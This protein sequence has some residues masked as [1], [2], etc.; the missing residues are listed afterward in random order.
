MRHRFMDRYGYP[1]WPVKF[2]VGATH[3]TPFG[4]DD[5]FRESD[6]PL[7]IHPATDRGTYL[8]D[9]E[10]RTLD[11]FAPFE[12]ARALLIDSPNT[13]F[14]TILRLFVAGADFELRIM[15]M[16]R[17]DIDQYVMALIKEKKRIPKSTFLGHAGNAGLSVGGSGHH[18]HLEIVSNESESPLLEK[19]VIERGASRVEH[20]L[21]RK[22]VKRW[23]TAQSLE[24]NLYENYVKERRRRKISLVNEYLC[25]R[26]DYLTGEERT[27]YN[28]KE[29]F[30]GL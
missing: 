4:L 1:D 16:R 5:T 20:D 30:N 7:R 18:T 25:R 11:V 9:G 12:I 14:G 3:T 2:R 28:S 24:G 22:D 15:H 10:T 23:A 13:G 8:S 26:V 29:C 6:R 19:L 17:E 27:F 21:N